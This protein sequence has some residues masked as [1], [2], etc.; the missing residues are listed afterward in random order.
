M[1]RTYQVF[2]NRLYQLMDAGI[3][4]LSFAVAWYVKFRSDLLPYGGHY[5]FSYYL[6]IMVMAIPIFLFSNWSA[7]LYQPM[8]SRSFWR[9][10]SVLLRSL[11]LGLLLFMSLLYFL[12]VTQ[13][14]RSVL[15]VFA[16]AFTL[17]SYMKHLG[18]LSVMRTMRS[19][20]Y[21]RKF[22]V[23]VGWT[24]AARRFLKSIENHPWFGYHILGHVS[25]DRLTES[26]PYLGQL[27]HLRDILEGHLVD[28]VLIC[29]SRAEGVRMPQVIAE[30]ETYGVQSLIVPDYFDLLPANPRFESFAGMPLIDTRYVP[31]DDALNAVLKRSF[32]IV[33]SFVVL[34]VLSPVFAMVALLVKLSSPGP[35]LF[36][37]E[38]AGRNRRI[39][40]M[41]KFR[42]MI[43]SPNSN[44]KVDEGWTTPNDPRRTRIGAF[45]RRTS[46][47]ELPQFWNV[48][49]GHMSVIGPRPER[50]SFV[51]RFRE[52]IPRYMVKHRV[53][54]GI[55]G[56][57]QVH[58]W[59]GDTSIEKRIDY[60]LD[61]IE[62]WSFGLDLRI[63]LRTVQISFRDENAY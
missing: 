40:T 63:V 2:W 19:R 28:Y 33:F 29:L 31:L 23:I 14:S 54:P 57:A 5:S 18:F 8:R 44:P 27:E 12:H 59:R 35:V 20:G 45:L 22:V 46:I 53:R 47:D 25:D 4:V 42:T 49:I 55:T 56:W 38:R 24:S 32:D 15:A 17:L 6:P 48:L 43:H 34:I 21:N 16:L 39:F 52:E 36:K 37:Q 58:G 11:T 62:N 60:D 13:F 3:V 1:F 10:T 61:Y 50:P 9:L 41:Y 30:C 26:V 51:E 7:G